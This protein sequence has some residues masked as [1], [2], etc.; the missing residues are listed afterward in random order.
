MSEA[1]YTIETWDTDLQE[2]TSQEGMENPTKDVDIHGLRRA[3]RELQSIGYSC[4]YSRR[5]CEAS[6]PSVFVYRSNDDE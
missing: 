2:F 5:Q 4:E 1:R 3:L 6:D